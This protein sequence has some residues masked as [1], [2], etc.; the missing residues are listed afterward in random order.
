MPPPPARCCVPVSVR[1]T[2]A[3]AFAAKQSACARRPRQL[4][5]ALLPGGGPVLPGGDPRPPWAPPSI[6]QRDSV[7]DRTPGDS[8]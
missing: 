2:L 7:E 4:F 5:L 1:R 3:E 8:Q 6:V